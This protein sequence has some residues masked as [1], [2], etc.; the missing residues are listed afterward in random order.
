MKIKTKTKMSKYIMVSLID[1]EIKTRNIS[2]L[3]FELI[4]EFIYL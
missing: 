3:S 1:L 2:K 4:F